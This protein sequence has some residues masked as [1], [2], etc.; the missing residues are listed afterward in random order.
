M[1]IVQG[2]LVNAYTTLVL[3]GKKTIEEVPETPVTL[4]GGGESTI[5]E[6]VEIKVAERTI[7]VLS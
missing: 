5:R 3:A 7:E 2:K 4:A 1:T 6:Q